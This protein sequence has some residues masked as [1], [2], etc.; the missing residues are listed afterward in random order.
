MST[1]VIIVLVIVVAFGLF[2][3]SSLL[4][5]CS[6]HVGF[7]RARSGERVQVY[8]AIVTADISFDSSALT[9]SFSLR[10]E[11]GEMLPVVYTGVV[12]ANFEYAREATCSGVWRDG[13]FLSD[14]MLLKCPSKYEGQV[15]EDS[16]YQFY[17]EGS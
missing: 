12:P 1:R 13:R 9:L 3:F 4:R 10:N 14:R 7:E 16:A 2:M 8:G 15:E 11:Q 5:S 6:P 17:D